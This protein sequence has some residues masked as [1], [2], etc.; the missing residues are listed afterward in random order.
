[1]VIRGVPDATISSSLFKYA[2]C[3]LYTMK[4]P[5]F[6]GYSSHT[7]LFHILG[8]FSSDSNK[9]PTFALGVPATMNFEFPYCP[10]IT[11]MILLIIPS[12]TS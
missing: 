1:M 5:S 7:P 11:G 8:A 4:F 9:N 10:R 12:S 3:F 6:S 2:V